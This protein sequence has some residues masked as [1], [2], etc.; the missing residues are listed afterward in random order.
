MAK[1]AFVTIFRFFWKSAKK[2]Q[3]NCNK[4]GWLWTLYYKEKMPKA[5]AVQVVFQW[6]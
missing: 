5:T 6:K 2:L 3:K 1:K 4:K